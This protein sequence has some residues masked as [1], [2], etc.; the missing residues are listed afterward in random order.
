MPSATL[1]RHRRIA[2][3]GSATEAMALRL[4]M[5]TV[6]EIFAYRE[7]L[8]R[9]APSFQGGHS[10][11][12]GAIADALGLTFPIRVPELEAMAKDEGFDPNVLWPW[13]AKQR[14]ASPF[15]VS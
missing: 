7:A 4:A 3:G 15:K 10:A 1:D 14:T 12:G 11:D 2:N 8:L 9:A 5:E 13:L 6:A